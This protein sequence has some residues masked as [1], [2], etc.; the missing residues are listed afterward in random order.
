MS[1]KKTALPSLRNQDWRTLKWNRN[2]VADETVKVQQLEPKIKLE[3]T[4]QKNTDERR[5]SKKIPR[6]DQTIQTK[7]KVPKLRKKIPPTIRGRM[8]AALQRTGCDRGKQILEQNKGRKKLTKKKTEWINNMETELRKLEESPQVNI[9]PDGLEATLEKL[10][11]W[12]AP[13]LDGIHGFWFKN[14]PPFTTDLLQKCI[15]ANGKLN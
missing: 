4:N 3:K 9:H 13:G 11:N 1:V 7:Q 12:K 10:S 8:G 14:S 5:K 6:Q 2:K 15:N